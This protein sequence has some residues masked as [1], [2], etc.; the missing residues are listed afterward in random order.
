MLVAVSGLPN[1]NPNHD[2]VMALF[3]ADCLTRFGVLVRQLEIELGP[4]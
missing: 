2:M 3:A 4:E 1:P